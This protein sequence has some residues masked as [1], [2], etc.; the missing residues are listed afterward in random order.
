MPRALLT[1]EKIQREKEIN[2]MLAE[3]ASLTDIAKRY[4]ITQQAAAKFLKV[5]GWKTK[6]ALR[7]EGAVSPDQSEKERRKAERREMRKAMKEKVDR[8]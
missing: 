2:L 4:D 1:R 7:R 6:E 5:R 8:S 3:G